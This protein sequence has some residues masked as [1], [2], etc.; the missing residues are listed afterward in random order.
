[1]SSN[2]V[3]DEYLC[4]TFC[5]YYAII[6]TNEQI[7]ILLLNVAG[8]PHYSPILFLATFYI[9]G[10]YLTFTTALLMDDGLCLL[11]YYTTSIQ[12]NDYIAV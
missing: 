6:I 12:R 8:W 10:V 2:G 1:M 3:H 5:R 9:I 11:L 4:R 7:L